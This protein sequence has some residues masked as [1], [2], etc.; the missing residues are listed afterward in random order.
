MTDVSTLHPEITQARSNEWRLMLDSAEGESAIKHAAEKYLPKPSGF[1]AAKDSGRAMYDAYRKRSQFPEM[2]TPSLSAMT[3]I[4]HGKEMQITLPDALSY[5]TEVATADGMSLDAFHRRITRNLLLIG[6]FGVLADAPEA[7]GDPYLAGYIGPAII[8]WDEDF[9]VLDETHNARDGFKW[10][11]V[12][13]FR[14]LER[15]NGRYVQSIHTD[16]NERRVEPTVLGGAAIQRIPFVVANAVDQSQNII[17]PPLI[18]IARSALAIYQLDADYR[19]QLFMSGQ[20]TLI[21]KN[22]E[23]PSFVGAGAVH[24]ITGSEDVDVDVYYVSPSC[25]GIEAHKEAKREYR[26]AAA[27]AGAKLHRQEQKGQESGEAKRL[28]FKSETATLMTV[29]QNSCALLEKSL[30]NVAMMKGLNENDVVVTPPSDLLDTIMSA[31]DASALFGVWSDGGMSWQTYYENL[32]RGGI[33]SAERDHE[34]EWKLIE[35]QDLVS[36]SE[37]EVL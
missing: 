31:T 16:E 8:N 20:E 9:Y 19:H 28:R 1:K 4:I 14:V 10:K 5:L 32:Q 17:T 3:G 6:R 7:G 22:C 2:V 37:D 26:E 13:Q 12:K 18:G 21:A 35:G 15:V 30:R 27:E 34:D 23:P 33:A 24:K 29:A 36:D 25:A 11:L